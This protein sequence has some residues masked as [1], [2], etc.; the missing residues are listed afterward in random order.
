MAYIQKRVTTDGRVSYRVQVRLKGS[1]TQSNTFSR[2][3]DAK[4]W[5][6]R[7]ESAIKEGRHFKTA[8]AKKHT[9][10]EVVDRY[11]SNIAPNLKSESDRITQLGWWKARLGAFVLADISP[12]LLST[13]RDNLLS[14][15]TLRGT[16][17][18]PASTTR[19]M[20]ALSHALSVAVREWGWM[21]DNPMSKV[22]RPKEPRGLVRFLSDDERDRLLM[23]CKA[24]KNPYLYTIVVLAIATGMRKG[25][26][27]NLKWSDIELDKGKITLVE[28]KNGEIRTVPVMG[29][30]HEVLSAWRS[31][32]T[33]KGDIV[34]PPRLK[35][36]TGTQGATS[37][38]DAWRTALRKA[39]IENF[40][41]HDLRHSAASY[42]AMNGATPGEIAEVLGH[43]TLQMVKRYA[44]L[45]EAHTAGVVERMNE[46]I[47]GPI[48]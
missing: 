16:K 42:L 36:T 34:F 24:S 15:I 14:E 22:S 39:G 12:A 45:S 37:I 19:Y 7:T 29:Y 13:H 31:V 1:P 40:R 48:G 2:K 9:L 35:S 17:R 21:E 20:A 32:A 3:T 8:E 5:G 4:E 44:H 23:E 41:F 33:S 38:D 11:L 18:S 10:A 47:F 46:K 28:T 26:I 30:A 27:L 43:K 25:E 6:N